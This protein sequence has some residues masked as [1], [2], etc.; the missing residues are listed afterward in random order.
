MIEPNTSAPIQ[1]PPYEEILDAAKYVVF[2]TNVR[3]H[4]TLIS[5]A[6]ESLTGYTA[7]ELIGQ[8]FTYLIR[9]DSKKWVENYYIQQYHANRYSTTLEFPIVTKQGEEKWVEQTVI[10]VEEDGHKRFQSVVYDITQRKRAEDAQNESEERYRNLFE[11]T[12]E[13]V[14]IHEDGTIVD[15][16]HSFEEICGWSRGEILGQQVLSLVPPEEH[17]KVYDHMG[18]PYPYETIGLRKDGSTFPV[19]V[20]GKGQTYRGRTVRVITVRDISGRKYAERALAES[21]ERY[22]SLFEATFEAVVIHEEGFI[23]DVNRSFETMY[24]YTREDVLGTDVMSIVPPEEHQKVYD[25]IGG[26]Y[27]YESIGIRKDGTTFPVEVRGKGQTY[28][29]RTVRVISLRDI[30]ERKAAERSLAESEERYRSLFEATFEAVVIHHNGPILD[31]NPSFEVMFD[32]RRDEV[33]DKDALMLIHPE[34]HQTV[35]DHAGGPY[36]YECLAQRKDGSTFPVE[37]RVKGQLYQG[38]EVRVASLRDISERKVAEDALRES[39]ERYR[40]LFDSTFEGVLIHDNGQVLDINPSFE[41]MFGYTREEVIV[42]KA[43][44]FAAPESRKLLLEHMN[45]EQAYEAM[46]LRKDGS[47][48]P[49]T[50][51]GKNIVLYDRTVRMISVRDISERK[52]AEIALQ[53]SEARYRAIVEDNT[54]FICRFLPDGTLT[55]V[56]E[57]YCRYFDKPREQLVGSTFMKLIPEDDWAGVLWTISQLSVNNPLITYEHRVIA[58]D[59]S[60]RWQQWTDR[61]VFDSSGS[62]VEYQAVG[63]DITERKQAEEALRLSET[64]YRELFE[65]VDDAVIVHDEESN[66]LDVNEA[67][68]RR[69]GYT[70][71]E[72]LRMKTIEIDAPE[73]ATG[74]QDRLDKQL[75]QGYLSD[76]GGVHVAKDGRRIEIDVNTK[77]IDYHGKKAVLALVR[78]IT[79][80]RNTQAQLNKRID[81]LTTLRE[82]DTEIGDMLNIDHVLDIALNAALRLSQADVGFIGLLENDQLQLSK[83]TGIYSQDMLDKSVNKDKGI[84]AR[85]LKTQKSEL[86]YGLDHDP[87]HLLRIPKMRAKIAIPLISRERVIGLM[88][89]EA[90]D[91]ARFTPEIF[92]FLELLGVR[93]ATALDNAWLYYKTELQLLEL[94]ELYDR[95]SKLEGL[96]TEMIRIASHDLRGPLSTVSGYLQVIREDFEAKG[97]LSE[98]VD[99]IDLA[100]VRMQNIVSG[101][102]SLERIQELAQEGTIVKFD[103]RGLVKKTYE[104]HHPEAGLKAQKLSLELDDEPLLVLCDP[105]QIH[106]AIANLIG[107]AI[108]YT[109]NE[110]K[111]DVRLRREGGKASFEVQD[112]G[113]G[114]P[115]AQQA[116]LFE[117]FFR[118]RM[119]ETKDIDGTGVGLNLVKNIVQRSGGDIRFQS[120][121]GKGST[122]GFVLPLMKSQVPLDGE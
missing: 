95:V 30:S 100:T 61:I 6:V 112:T 103:L 50:M 96:K 97:K 62:F 45:S 40:T 43:L 73:Y 70:R 115:A 34:W 11:A 33:L 51:Q 114:V 2:T 85:V 41:V 29:G 69:L 105:L 10:L 42:K 117:P 87:D 93:I 32:Y 55:F 113:Y 68:C 116:R 106:E 76:I 23:M 77:V 121:Y 22:R 18:G 89:L 19:E 79:P 35:L 4:F 64:R 81:E 99:S 65:G 58:P 60:I 14:I 71:E 26:P 107:N 72:L 48:F 63:R 25:H 56:N 53:K 57:A 36:P 109:P 27:P 75:S 122:F 47:V 108:K 13:A 38:K 102:L 20:R 80:L 5:A 49:V 98:Y 90:A 82:L 83:H 86:V 1:T 31:V 21:E 52:A 24:G 119:I 88:N 78:D 3:G 120:E 66:I 91:E 16:N 118:A 110:G 37:V 74:F 94:Q 28:R 15:V 44:D 84:L 46:A 67:A 101:I 39:E 92:R 8:H 12:F 59:G 111:I 104:E 54:E 9:E 7:A 17:Q